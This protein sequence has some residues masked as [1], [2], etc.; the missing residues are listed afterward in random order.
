M[1]VLDLLS[2]V[3]FRIFRSFGTLPRL[4]LLELL[5]GVSERLSARI[6]PSPRAFQHLI[7]DQRVHEA[8]L[9]DL[10]TVFDENLIDHFLGLVVGLSRR[11]EGSQA[12]LFRS[13]RFAGNNASVGMDIRRMLVA[14]EVGCLEERVADLVLGGVPLLR[15]HRL[16][17]LHVK[18]AR[19]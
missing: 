9:E 8:L 16:E 1:S 3:R 19:F 14:L 6:L 4:Q 10:Q 17:R 13:G 5:F 12:S 11:G 18:K 15:V 2:P 7:Q